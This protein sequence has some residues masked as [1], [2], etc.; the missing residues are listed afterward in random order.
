MNDSTYAPD[1]PTHE[2][3]APARLLD[4]STILA[5]LDLPTTNVDVPE[6]GGTVG[7]R[8][9]TASERDRYEINLARAAKTGKETDIRANLVG[10]CAVDEDG[11]RLFTDNQIGALSQKSGAV[12]DRLFDVIAGLSGMTP[13][14]QEQATEEAA[15]D[16][17]SDPPAGSSSA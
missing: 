13:P 11:R 2:V 3:P 6:W 10:R 14:A 15:E 16:F 9:A 7:V 4:A 12:L 17:T 8:G 5:A 1:E